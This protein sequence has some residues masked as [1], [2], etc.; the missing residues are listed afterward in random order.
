MAAFADVLL[1]GLAL[2]GQAVAI[3]GVLFALLVLG[4]SR[5]TRRVWSLVA[6]AATA[7]AVAQGL[8]LGV[9][10]AALSAGSSV[11]VRP[12]L[13][14]VFVQASLVKILASASLVGAAL[15]V[16]RRAHVGLWWTVLLGAALTIVASGAWTSHGVARLDHRPTLMILDS[17]HQLAAAAWI[18]GLVHLLVVAFAKDQEE[19]SAALLRRFAADGWTFEFEAARAALGRHV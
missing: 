1:R 2:S 13:P 14:A 19:R 3:G 7:V 4:P 11:T 16:R 18:G 15:A 12:L 8:A 6:L 10:I 5:S 9:L 17:I